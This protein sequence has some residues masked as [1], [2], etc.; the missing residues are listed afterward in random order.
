MYI[1]LMFKGPLC[2]AKDLECVTKT[3]KTKVDTSSCLKPCSGL[4]INTS[5]FREKKNI[6]E[7][8]PTFGDYNKYK[9]ITKYPSNK[10]GNNQIL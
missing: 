7:L 4:I 10:N 2:D 9:K 6:E 5:Q 3:K 8:F 1:F